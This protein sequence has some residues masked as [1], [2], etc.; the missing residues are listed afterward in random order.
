MDRQKTSRLKSWA[1]LSATE[2]STARTG[3]LEEDK[4]TCKLF[5]PR[6]VVGL[7][8]DQICIAFSFL[9]AAQSP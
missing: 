5:D 7:K 3:E 4:T 6:R 8:P 2:S 9:L 1:L